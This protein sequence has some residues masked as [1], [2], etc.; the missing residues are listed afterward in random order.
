MKKKILAIIIFVLIFASVPA[1]VYLIQK[2]QELRS[3]ALP[4]TVLSLE[5]ATASHNINEVFLVNITI[6][7]GTN[8]VAAAD[9]DMSYDP[10]VLSLE[11]ILPGTFF[12]SPT[13]LRKEIGVPGKIYYSL[14]SL[15]PKQGSGI[16][17]IISFRGLTAGTS[18]VTFDSTTIVAGIDEGNILENTLSGY[19]T[20]TGVEPT[21]TPGTET[22]TS[23]PTSTSVPTVTPTPTTNGVGGGPTSTPTPTPTATRTPTP[24]AGA[25]STSTP[26]ISPEGIPETGVLT[27]TLLFLTAG[28]V[29]FAFG[30]FAFLP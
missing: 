20:I 18:S 7:T 22:P 17:A 1:G 25:I 15:T 9:I 5:P 29:L 16:I 23:T 13:E 21:A 11:E 26:T 12:D 10:Q 28:A 27:P 30:L 8:I 24:A 3:R 14:G 6:E 19:Y 4:N 2:R